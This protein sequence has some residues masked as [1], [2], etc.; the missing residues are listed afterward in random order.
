MSTLFHTYEN[1]RIARP[2]HAVW[3]YVSDYSKDT[4]WRTGITEMTPDRDGPPAVGTNLKEVL[5]LGRKEYVTRTVVTDVGPGL[6]YRFAGEGTSGAV[7]GERIVTNDGSDASV[8]TYHVDITPTHVP[9][10]LRRLTVAWF[11]WSLRKDLNRLRTTLEA[12]S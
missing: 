1:V 3:T 6:R 4:E 2:A 12:A 5:H 9:L 11:R 7:S 8:L 10:G